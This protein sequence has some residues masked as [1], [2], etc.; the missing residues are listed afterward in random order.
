MGCPRGSCGRAR[1]PA[2]FRLRLRAGRQY[3]SGGPCGK[4]SVG[5]PT[6]HPQGAMFSRALLP[7]F[8]H[9]YYV[10]CLLFVTSLHLAVAL[11]VRIRSLLFPTFFGASQPTHLP[12]DQ[13]ALDG[14]RK[15]RTAVSS[16]E[17][18]GCHVIA[19]ASLRD[20]RRASPRTC[21]ETRVQWTAGEQCVRHRL[22]VLSSGGLRRSAR[23]ARGSGDAGARECASRWIVESA[24]R[25]IMGGLD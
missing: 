14:G 7:L 6:S 9:L 1:A 2:C 19:L 25:W 18:T 10:R 22:G 16:L 3:H 17:N 21:Q 12:E 13:S 15:T 8:L 11:D 4:T 23:A 20:G 24:E 5:M